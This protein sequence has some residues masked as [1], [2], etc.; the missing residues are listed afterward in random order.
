[1][2]ERIE[3]R[4]LFS[5]YPDTDVLAA[6]AD[7]RVA[8]VTVAGTVSS[9]PRYFF[10]RQTHA[11]HESFSI[12]TEHGLDVQVVDN[13][14]LAPRVPVSPGDVVAVSG[15]YIPVRGGG[16]IQDTHHCPGPGWHRGGWIEWHDQRFESMPISH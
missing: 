15:Q 12:V 5:R 7:H 6:H 16:L 13:V 10:G 3:A 2:N 1:M 8:D 9:A 11:W 4:A 14:D